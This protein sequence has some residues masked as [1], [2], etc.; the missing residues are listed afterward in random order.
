MKSANLDIKDVDAIA[1][2]IHH[3]Q[4]HALTARISEKVDFLS[5]SIGTGKLGG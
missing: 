3:M 5:L 4:A 1:T 2:T